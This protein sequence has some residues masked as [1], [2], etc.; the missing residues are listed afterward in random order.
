ILSRVTARPCYLFAGGGTGGHLTPG[1]AVAAELLKQDPRLRMIFAGSDRPLEKGLVA[2][3]G[4]E[5]HVLPVES[6][7]TLR[8][9]PFRFAWR[10]WNALRAA[11][12]LIESEVP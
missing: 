10:N 7:A 11:R 5:H 1:L 8:R 2:R 3:E 6:S 12:T 9:N 4:D